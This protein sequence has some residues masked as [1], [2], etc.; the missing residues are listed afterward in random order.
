MTLFLTWLLVG[1]ASFWRGALSATT[2][3]LH[4]GFNNSSSSVLND[5]AP[6]VDYLHLR[7]SKPTDQYKDVPAVRSQAKPTDQYKDAPA[8]RRQAKPTTQYKDAP[9]VRRQAKPTDQYKDAPAVRRQAK[10]TDQYKDA[11]SVTKQFA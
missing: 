10:P 5:S 7:S 6:I 3:T 4:Y 8:V 11:V 1:S 2:P 9:A